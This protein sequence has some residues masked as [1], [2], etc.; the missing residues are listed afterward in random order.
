MPQ[1]ER[2]PQMRVN[3]APHLPIQ[4][5]PLWSKTYLIL[6]TLVVSRQEKQNR[7]HRGGHPRLRLR[8]HPDRLQPNP[9]YQHEVDRTGH[10]HHHR[11]LYTHT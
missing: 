2:Q 10:L 7:H 6:S 8:L 1:Y 3:I 4:H 9:R 11:R 5:I